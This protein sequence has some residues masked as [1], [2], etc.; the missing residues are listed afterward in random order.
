MAFDAELLDLRVFLENA[1]GLVEQRE[2]LWLD[3]SRVELELDAV[4][5]LDFLAPHERSLRRVYGHEPHHGL[6]GGPLTTV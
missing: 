2:A 5:E 4:L 3:S 6:D 1:G